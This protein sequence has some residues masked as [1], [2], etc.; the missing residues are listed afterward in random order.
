MNKLDEE[1]RK[2]ILQ[3][4]KRLDL[5]KESLNKQLKEANQEITKWEEELKKLNRKK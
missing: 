2:T 5:R 1:E 3:N 4:L